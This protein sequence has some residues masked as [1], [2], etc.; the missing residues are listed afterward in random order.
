MQVS[1][2]QGEIYSLNTYS[3][4]KRIKLGDQS[5]HLKYQKSTDRKQKCNKENQQAKSWF[6]KK[7]NEIDEALARL[8][9]GKKTRKKP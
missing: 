6:F 4:E 9:K 1:C 7:M 8:I 2:A 3:G 5:K